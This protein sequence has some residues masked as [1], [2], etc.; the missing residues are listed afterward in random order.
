MAYEEIRLKTETGR[1]LLCHDAP[2]RNVCPKGIQTD[3]VIQS[4]RFENVS[5]AERKVEGFSDCCDC[6]A[7]C[8]AAC[9]RGEIDQPINIPRIIRDIKILGKEKKDGTPVLEG[10]H[11]PSKK[12]IDL[13]IEFCGVHCE[14]PFFLSS[15]VIGSNY[16]M[17]AKAFDLG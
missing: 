16:E 5:G 15:S 8:K 13:S 4:F 17:V 2:C 6:S 14:N 10:E 11:N 9:R 1:C 7:P 12:M 3:K